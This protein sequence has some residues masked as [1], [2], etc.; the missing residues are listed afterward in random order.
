MCRGYLEVMLQRVF[1]SSAEQMCAKIDREIA[2][3]RPINMEAVFNQLTLD[4]IGKA[5]FNYDF[6]ALTTDSPVIQ[7]RSFQPTSNPLCLCPRQADH[8]S[9][10]F[11]AAMFLNSEEI[12][13]KLPYLIGCLHCSQGNGDEGHRCSGILEGSL[14]PSLASLPQSA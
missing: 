12:L 6:D 4:V 8:R 3:G 13:S 5:V 10:F 1:A 2:S 9:P 11:L 14:L 7:V